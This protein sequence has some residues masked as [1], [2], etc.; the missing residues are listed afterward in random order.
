MSQK[1]PSPQPAVC[2]SERFVLSRCRFV[3]R[4]LED[5]RLPGYLGS[6]LDGGLGAAMRR[7]CLRGNTGQCPVC[8]ARWVCPYP[9]LFETQP[10]PDSGDLK[11]DTPPHP[12]IIEPPPPAVERIALQNELVS[13]DVVLVGQSLTLLPFL[14]VACEEFGRAGIGAQRSVFRLVRVEDM[15]AHPTAAV[16][17]AGRLQ[18]D[19]GVSSVGRDEIE[20]QAGMLK[21]R[22]LEL[23]FVTPVHVVQEDRLVRPGF[24][25]IVQSLLRRYQALCLFHCGEKPALPHEGLLGLAKAVQSDSTGL[26][27][28]SL[29]RYSSRQHRRHDTSGYLGTLGL[30]GDL[31]PFLWLLVLGQ[32]IHAGKKTSM[33]LGRY[34]M[35]V[36]EG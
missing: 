20:A 23:R 24:L 26:R 4:F 21:D 33:G 17:E 18:G 10:L 25:H 13:F 34:E 15:L 1:N 6:A 16:Y 31:G 30:T 29:E 27:L 2:I 22:S 8:V 35:A 36:R 7:V 19:G 28:Y 14:I 3:V 5:A 12:I 9:V 32:Y 11:F